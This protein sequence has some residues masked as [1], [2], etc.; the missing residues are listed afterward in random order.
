MTAPHLK[1]GLRALLPVL[2]VA[3]LGTLLINVT[4]ETLADRIQ[5]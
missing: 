3:V 4:R 1:S 2:L 5:A